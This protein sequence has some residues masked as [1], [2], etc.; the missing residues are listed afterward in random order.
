MSERETDDIEFDFFDEPDDGDITQRRRAVGSPGGPRG[1]RRPSMRPPASF[2][3]LLR[4]VGL[5]AAAILVVV[6]LVFWVRG[7]R[8]DQKV[9]SYKTYLETDLADVARSS[10]QNGKELTDLLTTVGITQAELATQL[11]GLAQQ[12]QQNVARARE[13]DAPGHLREA[14]INRIKPPRTTG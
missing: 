7:C 5:I 8:E 13:L 4:L 2:T 14:N 6:L 11:D 3:P 10:Q 1:P 12:E 9:E